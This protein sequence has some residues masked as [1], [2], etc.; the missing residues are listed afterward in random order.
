MAEVS[1]DGCGPA[2]TGARQRDDKGARKGVTAFRLEL[3]L[4]AWGTDVLREFASAFVDVEVMKD[5]VQ[6][7]LD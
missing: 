7:R 3:Q 4:E 6:P 5:V 2:T 1:F